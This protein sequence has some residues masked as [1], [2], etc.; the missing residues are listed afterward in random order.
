MHRDVL[1]PP[2]SKAGLGV[3]FAMR[4]ASALLAA[5]CAALVWRHRRGKGI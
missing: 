2:F 1:D 3:V 5:F 4:F